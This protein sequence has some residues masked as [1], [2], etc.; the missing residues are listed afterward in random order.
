ME[1]IESEIANND[2]LTTSKFIRQSFKRIRNRDPRSP[3]TG[4]MAIAVPNRNL[5]APPCTRP[6]PSYAHAAPQVDDGREPERSVTREY[7][8]W[9]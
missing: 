5:Y 8:E 4:S 7:S 1:K 6:Y 2:L 3:A 9:S